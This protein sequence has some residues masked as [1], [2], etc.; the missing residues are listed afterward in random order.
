MGWWERLIQVLCPKTCVVCR[1]PIEEHSELCPSCQ[2]ALL[3]T[4]AKQN[5]AQNGMY[6]DRA[7]APLYYTEQFKNSFHRYKFTGQWQYSGVYGAWMWQCLQEQEPDWKRFDY[8][9]WTPISRLRWLKRGYDQSKRLAQVVARE[10]AL[11]L[12]ATLH[13]KHTPEQSHTQHAEQ[14]WSNVK[15]A[16]CIRPRADVS[17]KRILLVDDI[18]TTGATLEEASSVLKKAG[19]QEVCCLT[20]ARGLR[21]RTKKK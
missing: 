8:I 6:F 2:K 14:R 7:I 12:V 19:A 17:G 5:A 11:P 1:E 3:W 9:T 13:R 18:I 16:Y 15:D 20:L 21:P 10:S 4:N